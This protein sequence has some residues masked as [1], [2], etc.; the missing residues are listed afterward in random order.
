MK[1]PDRVGLVIGM[2]VA[3]LVGLTG[4][5]AYSLVLLGSWV[6]ATLVAIG[7]G[8]AVAAVAAACS[9]VQEVETALPDMAA[10][11]PQPEPAPRRES[12]RLREARPGELPAP[13]VAAVMKGA[14][15][16]HAALKAQARVRHH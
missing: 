11:P 15:A 12:V 7:G 4:V 6:L 2:L 3:V 14:Q 1:I 8:A 5:A 16:T 10:A 9:L 13:Y